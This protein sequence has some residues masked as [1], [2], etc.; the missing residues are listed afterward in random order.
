MTPPSHNFAGDMAADDEAARELV[1]QL[2]DHR[3][4]EEVVC[5]R[6]RERL[7]EADRILRKIDSSWS[8]PPFDPVLVAQA[9]GIRCVSVKNPSFHKAMIMVSDGTPTI[10]YRE[11]RCP[12]RTR[13]NLFHEIAH[14]LFPDY[15]FNPVYQRCVRPRILE[16]DGQLEYLCDLAASEFMMPMDLFAEDLVDNGFGAGR[17]NRLCERFGVWPEA[18]CLRMVESDLE[19]CALLALE[20]L[21]QTR[22]DKRR[23]ARATDVADADPERRRFTVQYAAPS[24]SFRSSGLSMPRD[25]ELENRSCVYAAAR[26]RKPAAGDEWVD[27]G[28]DQGH[29]FHIEALPIPSSR[30]RHGCSTVLAF[31]YPQ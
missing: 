11:Q 16:P 5:E 8:P 14:T 4:V 25:L 22:R 2:G 3:A 13:H 10:L 29:S 18:A 19:R 12:G 26:S 31:F 6:V 30:R 27:L 15:R 24:T 21:R 23:L 20:P 17:V 9:L 28:R 1:R 7:D